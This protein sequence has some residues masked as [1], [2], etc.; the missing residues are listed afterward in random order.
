MI[1]TTLKQLLLDYTA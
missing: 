1:K